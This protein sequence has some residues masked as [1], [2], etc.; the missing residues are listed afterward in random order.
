[1]T[2][3]HFAAKYGNVTLL[4]ILLDGGCNLEVRTK[5]VFIKIYIY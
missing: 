2:M 3:L 5:Q 4:A 1:M